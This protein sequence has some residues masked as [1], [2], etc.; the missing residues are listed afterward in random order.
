[1]H[2]SL[3]RMVRSTWT[4]SGMRSATLRSNSHSVSSGIVQHFQDVRGFGPHFEP[5]CPMSL[6]QAS[7]VVS[8]TSW[9]V[10]S[11]GEYL[12]LLLFWERWSCSRDRKSTRLNS[13]HGY[14]SYAVFCLKKKNRPNI[15][16]AGQRNPRSARTW[17]IVFRIHYRS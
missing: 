10:I 4:D 14:I 13:S 2:R 5:P 8:K 3:Q 9:V 1:M 12:R 16:H 11:G 15:F 6:P 7:A 17:A